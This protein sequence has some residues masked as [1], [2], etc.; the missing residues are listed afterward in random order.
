M[1]GKKASLTMEAAMVLPLFM[2]FVTGLISFLILISLQSDI[3]LAMEE[4]ARSIGKK[5]YLIE[6]LDELTSDT[7][8]ASKDTL[9]VNTL[10]KDSL[11]EDASEVSLLSAGINNI[12]IKV[13]LLNSGLSDTIERSGILGGTGGFYTYNSSYDDENGILDIV[14]NYTY[15]IPFLP[16]FVEKVDFV[17]RSL[18]HVWTGSELKNKRRSAN[19]GTIVYVTPHGSVYHT[20]KSCSYLDLS[21]R[22]INYSEIESARNK[23]GSKYEKC[24]CAVN[25]TQGT[26][27]VT[28]YGTNWHSDLNCSGLK[29]TIIEKDISEVGGM[30]KCP[31]CGESHS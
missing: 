30:K 28:D 8:N 20:S 17:Q 23:S 4:T 2:I 24:S 1:K 3:Q 27:Y 19:K 16:G 11:K 31:K 15:K 25:V 7:D 21:I 18:S 14:V 26:V 22:S 9:S 13:L 12:S 6:R 29:R 10:A 5:A